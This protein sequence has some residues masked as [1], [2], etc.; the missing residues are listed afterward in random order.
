MKLQ[1]WSGWLAIAAVFGLLTACASQTGCG[2][3][4]AEPVAI[5][6]EPAP[7]EQPVVK[8][9]E[10][11]PVPDFK[12]LPDG[13]L[14]AVSADGTPLRAVIQFA[15]DESDIAGGDFRLLQEHAQRLNRNRNQTVSIQGHCDERGTR[16][17][18]LALGER[19]AMS[20]QDFMLANGV[21]P[22]QVSTQSYGEEQPVDSASTESAWAK[23]RRVELV[24][25]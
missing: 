8:P 16:E 14:V 20:V 12:R 17:Y 5:P 2:T 15:Y 7:V 23:N 24:Y 11:E 3:G 18:N 10:V 13:T 25:Q 22:S 9:V 6:E 4:A 21:R 1:N 19:R